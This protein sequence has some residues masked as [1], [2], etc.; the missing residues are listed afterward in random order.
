MAKLTCKIVTPIILV[1]LFSIVVFIAL[2]YEHLDV[3]FYIILLLLVIYIFSF[4]FSVGQ[5]FASPVKKLLKMATEVSKGNLDS[6]VHL[7]TKDELAD[8]ARAFNQIAEELQESYIDEKMIEKTASK[9]AKE[10]T[11]A[12]EETVTALE[13]KIKNRASEL[14]RILS[15]S[16]VLRQQIESSKSEAVKLESEVN[17]LTLKVKK[18][19][20]VKKK[21]KK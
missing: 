5:S 11:L 20:P 16:N 14:E 6:R 13:Q 19:K 2:N 18:Q 17:K 8:L 4:G 10:K 15:E 1:G 7:K 9:K 3:A 12:L 21:R